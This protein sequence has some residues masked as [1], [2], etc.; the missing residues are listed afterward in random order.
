MVP[1]G[2]QRAHVLCFS[3]FPS[4]LFSYECTFSD[5]RTGRSHTFGYAV[6]QI[7]CYTM[8]VWLAVVLRSRRFLCKSIQRHSRSTA[9]FPALIYNRTVRPS[10]NNRPS[11]TPSRT[12]QGLYIYS[13]P[14][15]TL[16]IP[17]F[18]RCLWSGRRLNIIL[19]AVIIFKPLNQNNFRLRDEVYVTMGSPTPNSNPT[20]EE[21]NRCL[22]K[23]PT[24]PSCITG[25]C[26][27]GKVRYR[28]EIGEKYAWPPGV[29]LCVPLVVVSLTSTFLLKCFR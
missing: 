28:A 3:S 22:D 8:S 26:L 1:C 11:F 17:D 6:F 20:D 12:R 19:L 7:W 15:A 25:G 13:Y 23:V 10:D 5:R 21:S 24:L 2:P 18:F 9:D 16:K 4:L 14:F 29:C 27:C